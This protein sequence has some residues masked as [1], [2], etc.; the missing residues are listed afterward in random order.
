M[1]LPD[2]EIEPTIGFR[3]ALDLVGI[4]ATRGY[5]LLK[6]DPSQLPFPVIRCGRIVKV[7]TAAVRRLLCVDSSP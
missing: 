3:R 5:E 7:P 2:P 4:G 6:A 1:K